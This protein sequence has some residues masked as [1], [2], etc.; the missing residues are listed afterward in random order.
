MKI[1]DWIRIAKISDLF[2]T[3]AESEIFEWSRIRSFYLTPEAHLNHFFA[4]HS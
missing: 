3:I 2:N 1:L 4:S